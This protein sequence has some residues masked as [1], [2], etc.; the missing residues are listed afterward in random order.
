MPKFVTL[1]NICLMDGKKKRTGR[2]ALP[3]RTKVVLIA[4]FAVVWLGANVYEQVRFAGD[5]HRGKVEEVGDYIQFAIPA[6]G[7]AGSLIIGDIAGAW[8]F[9][10]GCTLN[11]AAT[12]VLKQGIDT[13][14]PNGGKHS[15]PSGHTAFAFQGAA[16]IQ[17]RYGWKLG[18]FV[19]LLAAFVGFSRVHGEKHWPRDVFAGAAIG[20]TCSYIF[21]RPRNVLKDTTETHIK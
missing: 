15:F 2:R 20:L 21:T 1:N 16:F 17:R 6:A 14:R 19:F 9:V 7:L 11:L 13:T 5:P 18:I 3:R 12:T 10:Q 8:Q 4:I